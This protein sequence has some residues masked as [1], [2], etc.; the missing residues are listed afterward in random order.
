VIR[1]IQGA[2]VTS[3]RGL[4]DVLNR[5][6]IKTRRGREWHASQVAQVL[7]RVG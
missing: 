3:L 5:R 6:G 1:E 7:E 4:A 2:G